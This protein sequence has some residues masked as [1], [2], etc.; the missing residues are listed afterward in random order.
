[1]ISERGAR[2]RGTTDAALQ[3]GGWGPFGAANQQRAAQ[4]TS[5]IDELF[6]NNQAVS[7]CMLVNRRHKVVR[8]IDFRAG[9]TL[10]KRNF[11]INTARK[12]GIEKVFVLVE[13]DEVHTWTRLGFRREGSIPGFY[14]RSDAWIMG[15]VV[16]EVGPMRPERAYDD[17]DDDDD[18]EVESESPRT[19]LADKHL[20]KAKKLA[21]EL[22]DKP[23][24]PTKLAPAKRDVVQKALAAAQKAGR[25]LTGFEAFSRDA[26]RH[27]V[28]VSGKGGFELHA[29]YELQPSFASTMLELMTGPRDEAERL[30]VLSSLKTLLAKL[31]EVGAVSTFCLAPASDV[32]LGS[33]M[34]AAGFRRSA[35]LASHLEVGGERH[36]AILWSKKLVDN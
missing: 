6:F 28:S 31:V 34:V 14:R 23:L 19:A 35:L 27:H 7:L 20:D 2:G 13:R 15:A 17:D 26:E 32:L 36:D 5:S 11:V 8:V 16:A 10:A 29:S 1:V 25:A 22:L 18:L 24:P 33:C 3:G 9:A 21:K 4:T 30:L 12:E